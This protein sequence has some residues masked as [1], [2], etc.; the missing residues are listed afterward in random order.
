MDKFY[1]IGTIYKNAKQ[2]D[3]NKLFGG[4][5]ISWGVGRFAVGI[6]PDDPNF[7]AAGKTGG[8]STHSHGIT[9]RD[10]AA[11]TSG[12]TALTISQIPAHNHA[13]T[14]GL[15]ETAGL[16]VCQSDPNSYIVN[17]GANHAPGI[18]NNVKNFYDTGTNS[19]AIPGGNHYHRFTTGNTGS[20]SGHTHSIPAHNHTASVGTASNLP[21]YEVCYMWERIA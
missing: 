17:K 16:R 10:K 19:G 15:A 21:P 6:D 3:P 12:S 20:G 13:G 9:V 2:V 7:D 5:W 14:T 4:T 8:E 18:T 1:P 11:F